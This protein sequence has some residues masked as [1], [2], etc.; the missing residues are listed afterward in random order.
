MII[1]KLLGSGLLSDTLL[2]QGIRFLLKQRLQEEKKNYRSS[3]WETTLIKRLKSSPIALSTD[4]ANE[5]HYEIPSRFY[6]LVLGPY[7]KYSSG[8]WNDSAPS[9]SDTETKML[10][11]SCE[12]ADIQNGQHILDL[13]C[14][15][16]SLSLY[17]ARQ[18]KDVKVTSISNSRTQK[19]FIDSIAKKE[20]LPITVLT[21]DINTAQL[22][23]CFDRI[24]SIEMFE[25]M[26]NYEELLRKCDSVLSDSGKLFVHIFGHHQFTYTFDPKGASNWMAR[27]FFENGLMPSKSLFS[28]FNQDLVI[29]SQWTINGQHYEKTCN[30]WLQNM[31]D[32]L[33][34]IRVLFKE[35][36]GPLSKSFENY[37]RLFFMSCAE[38]F[39]YNN[40]EEWQVY[41][42]LFKKA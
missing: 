42:Y 31:D 30:A 24:V 35:T 16:G 34:E 40:G 2:R 22:H 20:K 38:L 33:E 15:W 37:W 5:Q 28:H 17:I 11:L 36:Y 14:G 23:G 9:F 39:G 26:R 6:E 27:Y 19:Q 29:D 13:G 3:S 7:L 4:S 10:R 32:N 41:H 1:D 21:C 12:R 18:F 25:H 8:Y